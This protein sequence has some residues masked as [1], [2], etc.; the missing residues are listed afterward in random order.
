LGHAGIPLCV[1]NGEVDE[2]SPRSAKDSILLAIVMHWSVMSQKYVA[3]SLL[4]MAQEPP[5]WLRA[6]VGMV[7]AVAV[8]VATGRTLGA[9][10]FNN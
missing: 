9:P 5:D 6:V 4:P 8:V 7:I 3:T 1:G 10:N 2:R